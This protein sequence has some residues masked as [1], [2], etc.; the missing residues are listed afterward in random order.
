M[1]DAKLYAP[2]P[3]QAKR[4]SDLLDFV[5]ENLQVKT[6][7]ALAVALGVPAPQICHIRKG[8]MSIGASMVVYIHQATD[9]P[10]RWIKGSLWLP[11]LE[12]RFTPTC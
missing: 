2:T 10:V 5:K 7:S 3:E 12:S 6:D 8:H 9:L 1:T 11:S 4:N